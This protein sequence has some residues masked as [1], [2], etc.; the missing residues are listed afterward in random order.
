VLEVVSPSSVPK[1]TVE[2]RDRY[3]EAGIAEYWLVD[4]REEPARFDVLRLTVRGYAATRRQSGGWLRSAVF[5]RS[6]RLGRD[7][8]LLGHPQFTLDVRD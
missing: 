7:A 6:F 4:A 5:G 1:D 8:D 2:L 3:A